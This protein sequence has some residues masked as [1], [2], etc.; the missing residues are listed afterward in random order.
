MSTDT[1]SDDDRVDD[2]L[3][4]G[5]VVN[6]NSHMDYT[7]EIFNEVDRERPPK[8]DECGFGQ[9]VFI[10]KSVEGDEYAI[11]GVIY[12]TQLVDPDQG[13]AGPRLAQTD[14]QQF[15]PGYVEERT[16]LAGVALL[17][18]AR[19]TDDGQI[20][21]PTY[22]M[23]RW[24]L[25]VE[26]VVMHCPDGV[27]RAFHTGEN[28]ALQL[29]YMERLLDIAGPLGAEVTLALIERLQG[30]FE[31]DANQRVLRV[32]EK[33]IRWRSSVDRGVMR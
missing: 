32:L 22:E 29:A 19:I 13:R 33:D 2:C 4:I 3:A 8:P 27:T 30:L 11:M 1:T 26:D 25:A 7:V 6:S 24:T 9:P 14:Q 21:S 17:G 20:E 12:D 16:T 5:T 15:T 23:P 18:T 31:S 10:R 28:D